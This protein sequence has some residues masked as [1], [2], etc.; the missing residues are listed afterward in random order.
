MESSGECLRQGKMSLEEI[1]FAQSQ[2]EID[3]VG[4]GVVEDQDAILEKA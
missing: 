2:W 4:S 3:G 1:L